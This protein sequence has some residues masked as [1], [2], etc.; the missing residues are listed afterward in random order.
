MNPKNAVGALLSAACLATWSA[1]A[2][3]QNQPIEPLALPA[4]VEQ[5]VDMVYVDREIGVN[6]RWR[7]TKLDNVTFARYAGAPLDLLQAINPLYAQLRRGLVGY[8]KQW[9]SLP[10]FRIDTGPRLKKGDGGERVTLLRERLGLSAG[11]QFDEE[12]KERVAA[13]QRSMA[14]PTT[15]SSATA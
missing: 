12:L 7:N 5:G 6:I 4:A 11:S 10:Q 14:L 9:S 13:Y 15:V 2:A 1:P 8:Q 3:A